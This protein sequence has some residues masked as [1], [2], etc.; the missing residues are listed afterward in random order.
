[1]GE[2]RANSANTKNF[3][4]IS[5]NK[6]VGEL[7][8]KKWYSFEAEIVLT[9]GQQYQLESKG[10]WDSKIELKQGDEVL[11]DIKMGWKGIVIKNYFD[12]KEKH[13]LLK[14]KGLLGNKFV[15]IDENEEPFMVAESNFKWNKLNFDYQIE[16]NRSFDFF[17]DND[18]KNLL[19]L[20]VLHCI[21]YYITIMI[22]VVTS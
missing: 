11:L 9:N 13:F 3:S 19:L 20:T 15:L 1:M 17:T 14:Q 10:F 22:A 8:Y 21:N 12:K 18:N 2:Y 5:D 4:L 7:L 6:E 16:T